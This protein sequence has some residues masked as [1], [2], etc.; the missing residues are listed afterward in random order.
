MPGVDRIFFVP[1]CSPANA[2]KK[3]INFRPFIL[4]AIVL[5]PHLLLHGSPLFENSVRGGVSVPHIGEGNEKRFSFSW[6][7]SFHF[8]PVSF[9]F[10]FLCLP[11]KGCKFLHNEFLCLGVW[12]RQ[13][14]NQMPKI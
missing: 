2:D 14:L 10:S 11:F 3:E 12:E 1:L 9:F 5:L 8:L 13:S 7:T 4:L 6:R